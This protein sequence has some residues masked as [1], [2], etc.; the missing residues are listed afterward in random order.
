[1]KKDEVKFTVRIN[2]ETAAKLV[3]T[4]EYYGRSQNRQIDWIIKQSIIAFE[5]EYGEITGDDLD[6]LKKDK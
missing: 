4:A 2:R 6:K 3:Y 1:M 5:K